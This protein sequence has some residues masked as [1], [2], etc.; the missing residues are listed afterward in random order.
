MNRILINRVAKIEAN[1]LSSLATVGRNTHNYYLSKRFYQVV[2]GETIVS[3][4]NRK[5]SFIDVVHENVLAKLISDL[6]GVKN[7]NLFLALPVERWM[8]DAGL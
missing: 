8:R 6:I 2:K 7:L 4:T 1:F 3:L 5:N